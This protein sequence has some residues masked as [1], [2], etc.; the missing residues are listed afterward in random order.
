MSK[1]KNPI[2]KINVSLISLN[3]SK[4]QTIVFV[5][6]Q[7]NN[8]LLFPCVSSVVI[9]PQ[10]DYKK[11]ILRPSFFQWELLSL[12]QLFWDKIQ[13]LNTHH[14]IMHERFE[15][16]IMYVDFHMR[17]YFFLNSK[18]PFLEVHVDIWRWLWTGLVF[19][20]SRMKW[21]FLLP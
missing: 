7:C 10:N 6:K 13:D 20:F 17:H 1:I 5:S 19:T 15:P 21:G 3:R 2:F 18:K 16:N 11:P 14:F 12:C 8:S 9:L 4:N